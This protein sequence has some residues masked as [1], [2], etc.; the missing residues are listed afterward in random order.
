MSFLSS[1]GLEGSFLFSKAPVASMFNNQP[2]QVLLDAAVH[3]L[4]E[5]QKKLRD[6]QLK[7]ARA[8]DVNPELY[9]LYLTVGPPP[10]R[11]MVQALCEQ[12]LL[13]RD[14]MTRLNVSAAELSQCLKDLVRR[15]VVT[16][17][18]SAPT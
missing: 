1:K 11:P 7:E 14:V 9:G 8:L 5:E 16:L 6:D 15:G 2:T 13:P 17:R 3:A 10:W 18:T 4:N 12:R